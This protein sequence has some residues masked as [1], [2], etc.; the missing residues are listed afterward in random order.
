MPHRRIIGIGDTSFAA[1]DLLD[2]VRPWVNRN[3]RRLSA[4]VNPH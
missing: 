2:D 1:I 4:N 3:A